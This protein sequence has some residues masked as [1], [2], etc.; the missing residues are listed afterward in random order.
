[1]RPQDN[2]NRTGIRWIEFTDGHGA[3]LQVKADAQFLGVTA[4]PYSM[5]DLEIATHDV[6]LPKRDYVTVSVDGFQ[7]GVGGD[8]SELSR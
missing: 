7:P 2:S 5:E 8:T 4:W 3:G 1:V 6:E